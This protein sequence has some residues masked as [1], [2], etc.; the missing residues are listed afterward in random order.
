MDWDP[1]S[2]ETYKRFRELGITD[3]KTLA[4]LVDVFGWDS[5]E[6]LDFVTETLIH[7]GGDADGFK[8]QLAAY[9][10]PTQLPGGALTLLVDLYASRAAAVYCARAVVSAYGIREIA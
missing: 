5:S 10:G 1:A 6:A 9:M 3:P 2:T 8:A 7:C 4:L